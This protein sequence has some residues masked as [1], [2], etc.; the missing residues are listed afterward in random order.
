MRLNNFQFKISNLKTIMALTQNLK[1]K[2]QNY[3]QKAKIL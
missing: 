2:S 1:Q 3:S